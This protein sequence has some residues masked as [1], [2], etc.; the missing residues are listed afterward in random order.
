MSDRSPIFNGKGAQIGY[1][2]GDRAFDLSG[3]ERCSYSPSTGNLSELSDK[4]IVGYIALDG[5]FVG[6]TS[7]S[8][9][10]F[11]K[12]SGEVHPGR[13]LARKQQ[14]H[15]RPKKPNLRP[16]NSG[17]KEPKDVSQ[18]NT[19]A[20]QPGDVIEHSP[21]VSRPAGDSELA[22]NRCEIVVEEV[23]LPQ[24]KLTVGAVDPSDS[25]STDNE[26]LGRAIGMIRSAL[27]KGL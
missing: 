1:L 25:S 21:A 11:G 3:R 13:A 19:T 12:P 5:T 17:I 27:E 7:I 10:L 26:L 6:L 9:Q 16:E 23:P 24:G 8:D 4:R 22:L 15:L 18:R 20:P 14:S 2:E